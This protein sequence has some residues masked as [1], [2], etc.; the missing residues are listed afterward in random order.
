M[1]FWTS[2]LSEPK[3][4]HRFLVTLPILTDLDN[5]FSFQPYLAKT[6]TKPSYEISET[7]HQFLGNTYYY[8]GTVTWNAIEL[9]IVNSVNPDGNKLLYDALAKSGYLRPDIQEDVFFNPAQ[10][11][12]TVNKFDATRN[13]GDVV[14]Q[15]LNGMGG[16]VGTWS[17]VNSWITSATFG[18]L[19][20]AGDDLLNI[21]IGMRYDWANYEVG[22]AVAAVA[23]TS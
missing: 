16:L 3:R 1:P 15:E 19:D 2:A 10:A 17:L 18:D 12:G 4:Q 5:Q 6:V 11:P 8:P 21:T 14:I 7:G 22:P 20:Y 9:T 13:L 23:A